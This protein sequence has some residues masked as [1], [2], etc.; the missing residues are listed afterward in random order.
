[1]YGEVN[2]FHPTCLRVI[3]TRV[4]TPTHL[5]FTGVVERSCVASL[6]RNPLEFRVR[7]SKFPF[8]EIE[9]HSQMVANL[10]CNMVT[11]TRSLGC[12]VLGTARGRA[13]CP[14]IL[15]ATWSTPRFII[16]G[17]HLLVYVTDVV[18][19]VF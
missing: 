1:M 19:I 9:V 18:A 10:S 14:L 11:F 4:F 5:V 2:E 7:S 12:G 16:S 6:I 17:I 15:L 8:L 3:P 13:P